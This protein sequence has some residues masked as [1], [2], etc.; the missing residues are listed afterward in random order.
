MR[1]FRA[2]L[3]SA[4]VILNRSMRVRVQDASEIMRKIGRMPSEWWTTRKTSTSLAQEKVWRDKN[5]ADQPARVDRQHP[6]SEARAW[7]GRYP[8][9]AT[10]LRIA[11]MSFALFLVLPYLL[12]IIYRF[13]DPPFSALMLRNSALGESF[14]Y[15]WREF[16]NISPNLAVAAVLAEDARFC[17]HWGVDWSAVGDVLGNL[18]EGET[19]RGASTIPMQTAKNLFLW[20]EQN[21]VRK[22]LEVPLAYFMTLIWP[23]HRVVEIYLNIAEWGPGIYGAEAAAQYHFGKPA[24]SLAVGEA[25]LLVAALPNPHRRNAGQPG[26]Q[27]RRL[28]ARIQARMAREARDASCVFGD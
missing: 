7:H 17:Q 8:A 20:P 14:D 16:E 5:E 13:A 18:E 10:L 4:G 24:A 9:I 22:A 26:P 3:K 15:R 2:Q 1:Q 27:T 23:K 19:P 11:A 12:I 28:A 21:Y 25:A 6:S